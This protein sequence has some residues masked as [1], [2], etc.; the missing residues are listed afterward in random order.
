M[1]DLATAIKNNYDREAAEIEQ[2]KAAGFNFISG[3]R[4]TTHD[5]FMDDEDE[6]AS[7][8]VAS[9]PKAMR[10]PSKSSKTSFILLFHATVSDSRLIGD[11]VKERPSGSRQQ[12]TAC[13]ITA[14][15]R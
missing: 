14:H 1:V 9:Q 4:T 5:S 6:L 8:D 2:A 12:A 7:S 15:S 11:R 13:S 3:P 10:K